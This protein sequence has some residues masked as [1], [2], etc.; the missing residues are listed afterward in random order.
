LGAG[1]GESRHTA[2][3][4]HERGNSRDVING[5]PIAKDNYC[6]GVLALVRRPETA[7]ALH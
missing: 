1:I 3:P 4:G 5:Q 7:L 2:N 6:I